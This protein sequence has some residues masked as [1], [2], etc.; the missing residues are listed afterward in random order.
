MKAPTA[1]IRRPAALAAGL[2]AAL[3]LGAQSPSANAGSAKAGSADLERLAAEAPAGAERKRALADLAVLRELLGDFEGAAAA[4]ADAA[5][6]DASGRDDGSLLESARLLI[7]LGEFGRA[8]ADVRT[9]LLTGSDPAAVARA[10]YLGALAACIAGEEGGASLLAA[11]V[12]DEAYA[13]ERPTALYVLAAATG[14]RAWRDKLLSDHP[15]SPEALVLSDGK[16]SVW[17]APHW[18]FLGAGAPVPE[19]SPAEAPVPRAEPAPPALGSA[20]DP[21]GGIRLQVGLF[22]SE[23]NARAFVLRLEKAGFAAAVGKRSIAGKE[24]L[25]VTVAGGADPDAAALR[26]KDAGFESFP[27]LEGE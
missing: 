4:W 10:R 15:G 21:D 12:D 26:L 18:L 16:V 3:A 14:D 5:F 25:T 20:K 27:L 19:A 6:S 17:P 8:S 7:A 24:Y 23:A 9:V 22:G 2:A 13:A 11:F 1:S